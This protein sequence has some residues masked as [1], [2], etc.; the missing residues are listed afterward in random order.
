MTWPTTRCWGGWCAGRASRWGLPTTVPAT[1]VPETGLAP[2]LSHELRW[3]RTILSLAPVGFV[4][5]AVQYPL[6]WALLCLAFSSGQEWAWAIFLAA[7]AARALFGR[8]IDRRL[9]LSGRGLAGAAP[10][11]WL[12]LRDVLSISIMLASY[13]SDQVQWR[14]QVLN[15]GAMTPHMGPVD[16]VGD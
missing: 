11:W 3:S 12:P 2:L 15:A 10:I 4:L 8:G 13:A 1:T 16:A 7:W 5:S 9:A 14:G 6:A